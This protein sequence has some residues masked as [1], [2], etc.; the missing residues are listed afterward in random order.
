MNISI[1]Q[2]RQQQYHAAATVLKKKQYWLG[3]TRLVS[4]VAVL[5]A[6]YFAVVEQSYT[7][8]A[9]AAISLVVFLLAVRIDNTATRQ[10]RYVMAMAQVN[11]D[12]IAALLTQTYPCNDGSAYIAPQHPYSYDIDLFGPQSFFHH[13]NRCTSVPGN[14]RLAGVLQSPDTTTILQRQAAVKELTEKLQYRQSL[15]AHGLNNQLTTVQLEQVTHWLEGPVTIYGRPLPLI[16]MTVLPLCFVA[17]VVLYYYEVPQTGAIATGLFI[18]NLIITGRYFTQFKQQLALSDELGKSLEQLAAQLRVIEQETFNSPL[19]RELQQQLSTH[20]V[21]ASKQIKQLST[22]FSNLDSINNLPAAM[23]LNGSA[24]F[25]LRVFRQIEKWKAQHRPLFRQWLHVLGE[26][27]ALNSMAGF[28]FNNP[29]FIV[30]QLSSTEQLVAAEVAH[31]LIAADKRVAN[32]L[33]LQQE[34]F[35]ILTGS[36]MSGKST[37][38]RT[39]ALNLMLARA[40]S[41]V[42]ARSFSFYPFDIFVSMRIHDSLLNN[43]SFFYAELKRLHNIIEY[44]QAGHKTFILLDEILRGTNSNDKHRGTVGLIQKLAA[45]EV[46]GLIATHDVTVGELTAQYPSYMA[47]KCFEAQIINDELLFDYKLKEGVCSKLSASFLMQQMG[48]ID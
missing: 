14:E 2:Q 45:M 6:A 43:E 11:T 21:V 42:C 33:Q 36:N 39:L 40:G 37:F 24:L 35:I 44:V 22:L 48:I 12:E 19:L 10:R 27:E 13:F 30:P 8:G 4:I 16:L 38:L 47:N 1:Y 26:A 18:L 41:V 9:L 29:D 46:C 28:A 25:H 34:K 17:A 31:P 15:M 7:L 3:V 20:Q 23:A 5:V 32:T